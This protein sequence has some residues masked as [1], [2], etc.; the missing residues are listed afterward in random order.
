[1]VESSWEILGEC[2]IKSGLST[3]C[4]DLLSWETLRLA[5]QRSSLCEDS[6]SYPVCLRPRKDKGSEPEDNQV[7]VAPQAASTLA[8][9]PLGQPGLALQSLMEVTEAAWELRVPSPPTIHPSKHSALAPFSPPINI[10]F[11]QGGKR[12]WSGSVDP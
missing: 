12:N 11:R 1:M 5:I 10:I 3:F 2:E 4:Q 7:G 9:A 8:L 6:K